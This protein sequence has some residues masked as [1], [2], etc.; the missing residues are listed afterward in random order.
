M[1]YQSQKGARVLLGLGMIGLVLVLMHCTTKPSPIKSTA[2]ATESVIRTNTTTIVRTATVQSTQGVGVS[3]TAVAVRTRPDVAA[4]E[5]AAVRATLGITPPPTPAVPP[6]PTRTFLP[7]WTPGPPTR[8][9]HPL[10]DAEIKVVITATV[11]ELQVGEVVTFTY[12]VTNTGKLSLEKPYCHL[13][14]YLDGIRQDITSRPLILDPPH[15]GWELPNASFKLRPGVSDMV[16][17]TLRAVNPGTVTVKGTIGG[18]V[19]FR[20]GGP[21]T[22]MG[23]DSD[24]LT[25]RVHPNTPN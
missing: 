1:M 20:P 2:P 24:S 15:S 10:S 21:E 7:T 9:P 12:I 3:E 23:W 5:T 19:A 4:S 18:G 11:T 13:Q 22:I 8:T 17:L 16:T 14:V 25:I 6:T